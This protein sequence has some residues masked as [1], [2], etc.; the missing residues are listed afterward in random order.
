MFSRKGAYLTIIDK[1]GGK[2]TE[3]VLNATWPLLLCFFVAVATAISRIIPFTRRE[4]QV[5]VVQMTTLIFYFTL[6][7]VTE[8]LVSLF[9]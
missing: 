2:I 5:D 3:Y 9:L 7:V 6:P 4:M 8:S 1:K